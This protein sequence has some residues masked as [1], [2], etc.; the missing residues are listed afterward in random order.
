MS[1][2]ELLFQFV[3]LLST[4]AAFAAKGLRQGWIT[5]PL[6]FVAASA[7]LLFMGCC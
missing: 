3:H 6:L 5:V 7:V 4:G 2:G 1:G